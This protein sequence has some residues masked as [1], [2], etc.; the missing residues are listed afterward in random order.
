MLANSLAGALVYFI[1]RVLHDWSDGQCRV[2]LQ[3][4]HE[5]MGAESRI[6]IHESVM[7]NP[8]RTKTSVNELAMLNLGGKERTE[9]D[10]KAL[11]DSVG[12]AIVGIWRKEKAADVAVMECRRRS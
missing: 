5:A 1:K 7:T 4:L 3:H 8:P 6:L 2:I 9:E 11:L 10:W 12:L